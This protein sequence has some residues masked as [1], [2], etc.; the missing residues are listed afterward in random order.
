MQ[1][2]DQMEELTESVEES[3]DILDFSYGKMS[4]LL[5]T[6]VAVD[7]PVAVELVQSAKSA[8]DAMLVVA[9]KIVNEKTLTEK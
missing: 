4:K 5:E 1:V 8:R 2:L 9:N 3:L 6:P 7:D